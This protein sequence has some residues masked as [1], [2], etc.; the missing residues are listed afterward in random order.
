VHLSGD[1]DAWSWPGSLKRPSQLG[2]VL[3][4]LSNEAR[5]N[6]RE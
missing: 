3:D 1:D 5:D 6:G 2:G 4:V